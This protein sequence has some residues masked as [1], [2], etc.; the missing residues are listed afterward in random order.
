MIVTVYLDL[1][2]LIACSMETGIVVKGNNHNGDFNTV[3]KTSGSF[4]QI[5]SISIDL[6]NANDKIS[7]AGKCEHFSIRGYVSEMRKKDWKTCWPFQLED[8][9]GSS[10]KEQT[11]LLPDL[12]VPK[13][14]WWHCQ[15]CLRDIKSEGSVK[16]NGADFKSCGSDCRYDNHHASPLGDAAVFQSGNANDLEDKFNHQM[17]ESTNALPGCGSDEAAGVELGARK[18]N[19]IARSSAEICNSGT[20]PS[21]DDQHHTESTKVCLMSGVGTVVNLADKEVKD[22]T[23]PRPKSNHCDSTEP[24]EPTNLPR[25]RPRKVRR[26]SEILGGNGETERISILELP[27]NGSSSASIAVRSLSIPQ[28]KV[29]NQDSTRILGINRKRKLPLHNE[30][31]PAEMGSRRVEN[32]EVLDLTRDK[33]RTNSVPGTGSQDA[34]QEKCIRNGRENWRSKIEVDRSLS[35]GVKKNKKIQAV[36]TCLSNLE[37]SQKKTRKENQ[38][39]DRVSSKVYA[40]DT[41]P[42]CSAP[43]AFMGK[44]MDPCP[45]HSLRT[46]T[47][48]N[49]Y[50]GKGKVSQVDEELAYGSWKDGMLISDPI[51]QKD[52]ENI[53]NLPMAFSFHP[54]QDAFNEKGLAKGLHPSLD[55]YLA[56]Q[57]YHRKCPPQFE[58]QLPL[59]LP[60]KENAMKLDEITRRCSENNI[61]GE[62]SFPYK[63]GSAVISGKV[64]YGPSSKTSTFRLPFLNEKHNYTSQVK[65]GGQFHKQQMDI[66]GVRNK[67]RTIE[68]QEHPVI[69]KKNS[70]PRVEKVSEQ[71]TDEIREIVELMAKNQHERGLHD[72]ENKNHLVEKTNTRKKQQLLGTNILIPSGVESV[73]PGKRNLVHYFSASDESLVNLT[74]PGQSRAPSGIEVSQSQKKKLSGFQ[75]P[76]VG[77]SRLNSLQFSKT[78]G[79]TIRNGTSHASLQSSGGCQLHKSILQGNKEAALLWESTNPLAVPEKVASQSAKTNKLL[80]CSGSLLK[81]NMKRDN[82]LKFLSLNAPNLENLNRNLG[83]ETFCRTSMERPYP[84]RHSGIDLH[85]KL[86][87]SLDLYPNETIPAMH[88]L[89]LMDAGRQ[90]GT[91]L[92]VGVNTQLLKR[93]SNP[94]GGNTELDFQETR[95][96][97]YSKQQSSEHGKF[98]LAKKP[99]GCIVGTPMFAP[100]TSSIQHD[101]S[102][103]ISSKS[104]ENEKQ[105]SSYPSVQN[106]GSKSHEPISTGVDLSKNNGEGPVVGTQKKLPAAPGFKLFGWPYPGSEPSMQ[107]NLEARGASGAL[108]PPK[109]GS[110]SD[111]CSVN[112]NPADFTMPEPGNVYMIK[113]EDFKFGN[114]VRSGNRLGLISL[115]G[116]KQHINLKRTNKKEHAKH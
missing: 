79:G 61:V 98:K 48:S 3:V 62:S 49:M 107:C 31:I 111:I 5:D 37:L 6:A 106:R 14:K 1:V 24:E 94:H 53:Q 82:D 56:A 102:F 108:Q 83:T 33:E 2:D 25:R 68:A 93:P 57:S 47:K 90:S 85:Q 55:N 30:W 104:W 15:N 8:N 58:N 110:E 52:E 19:S 65:D 89:S 34:F 112:R 43:R 59:S 72:A 88:L 80:H 113:G 73:G 35:T 86:R 28:G 78:N 115:R 44:G 12:A 84:H 10:D 109:I 66:T 105:K 23:T 42:L 103:V 96:N 74:S 91:S 7:H 67:K 100:S 51:T 71:E 75:Y 54:A 92:N 114:S 20:L 70:Q 21:A 116:S 76:A 46:G 101:N 77:S 45:G 81:Q 39:N 11:S 63:Y 99:H 17:P 26:M 32:N 22:P 13:F 60:W 50:K 64:H 97:G 41:L 29:D 36:D 69:T 87:W 95:V 40:S 18:L 27:Y 38:E 16:D 4:I 9:H